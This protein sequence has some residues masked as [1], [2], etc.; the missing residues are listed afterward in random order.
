MVH[1][2]VLTTIAIAF[3][4]LSLRIV[5]DIVQFIERK[6]SWSKT[7]SESIVIIFVFLFL[8]FFFSTKRNHLNA[9]KDHE[10]DKEEELKIAKQPKGDLTRKELAKFT[11]SKDDDTPLLLACKGEIFDVTSSKE[12]YGKHGPYNLF[13]GKD[14]SRAFAKVSTKEEHLI[15]DCRDLFAMDIDQL[16]DWY[17]KFSDKYERVGKVIDSKYRAPTSKKKK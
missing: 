13:L 6:S 8:S 3:S 1:Q 12:F 16:E 7:Y 10:E 4:V 11:G 2:H 14:C 17:R 15:A 9:K 5:P